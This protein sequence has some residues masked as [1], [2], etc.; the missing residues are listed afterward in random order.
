M[1]LYIYLLKLNAMKIKKL[2][3]FFSCISS[4]SVLNAQGFYIG[5]GGGYGL[6]AAKESGQ[7]SKSTTAGGITNSTQTSNPFSYG[8]GVNFGLNVGYMLKKNFGFE[9]GVSYLMGSVYTSTYESI[10][11]DFSFSIKDE[12][13]S[14]GS[15]IRLVPAVKVVLGEKKLSLYSKAGIILGVGS[16]MVRE[17]NYSYTFIGF[18]TSTYSR[19]EYSGGISFGVHGALG[20]NYMLS[21]KIGLALELNGNYQDWAMK[22]RELTDY[23]SN[24]TNMLSSYTVSELET[25]YVNHYTDDGVSGYTNEPSKQTKEYLPFSSIGL[26]LGIHISLGKSE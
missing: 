1:N 20:L 12:T 16:K 3:L 2:I 21:K 7:D 26:N 6:G 11:S 13:T 9:L 14:K 15:M 4:F 8:Q 19:S 22:K 18:G 25:I 5:A 24:G 23:T 17:N 10:N